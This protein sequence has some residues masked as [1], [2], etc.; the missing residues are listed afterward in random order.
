MR[1]LTEVLARFS[2]LS[3]L[4]ALVSREAHRPGTAQSPPEPRTDCAL[5]NA[6][7]VF[8]CAFPYAV[9]RTEPVTNVSQS[10]DG[11]CV[12]MS[13]LDNTIRLF[14]KQTGEMLNR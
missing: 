6:G 7:I 5:P 1:T 2:R 4:W 11:N 10:R 9:S 14:D 13:C 3:R 8:N 12:L